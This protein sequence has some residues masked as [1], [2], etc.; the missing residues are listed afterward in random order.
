MAKNNEQMVIWAAYFDAAI[1]RECGRRI[2]KKLAVQTPDIEKIFAAAKALGLNPVLE[3]DK[4]YPSRW[5]ESSGRIL[6]D[7]KHSKSETITMI[8]KR[9]K[10]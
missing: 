1:S 8:A 2:S 5:W 6:V 4:K 9:L 3:K 7:R 10:T